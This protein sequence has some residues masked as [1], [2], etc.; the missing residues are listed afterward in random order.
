MLENYL[1][2]CGETLRRGQGN[3]GFQFFEC[4][5]CDGTAVFVDT[6][7]TNLRAIYG[8]GWLGCHADADSPIPNGPL[9]EPIDQEPKTGTCDGGFPWGKR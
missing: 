4:P 7:G 2:Q 8:D 6:A 1:C 3:D 9:V 5:R